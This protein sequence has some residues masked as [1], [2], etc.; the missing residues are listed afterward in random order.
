MKKICY[1]L[2]M[3]IRFTEQDRAKVPLQECD[4]PLLYLRNFLE[5]NKSAI[6]LQIGAAY[7][8]QNIANYKLRSGAAERLLQAEQYVLN[9]THGKIT[10]Q[11]TDAYRPLELQRQYFNE[12]KQK[13]TKAG[14]AGQELYQ[15][16]TEVIADPDLCPPHTTGG[17]VDVT[18]YDTVQRQAMDMG[19]AV[20]DIDNDLR[21]LWHPQ[22]PLEALKNR[23]LLFDAMRAA[24]F[25]EAEEEWWHYSYGDQQW[26]LIYQ[27]PY[28]IYASI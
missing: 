21:Y 9:T 10:L 16:V 23:Q 2:T 1:S 5:K 24:G 26:A 19:S 14:L 13:F 7:G 20:D 22:V 18:L 25:A 17:T 15:R 28:A 8:A 4:E 6:Q 12:I 11:L 3:Q 27:Q